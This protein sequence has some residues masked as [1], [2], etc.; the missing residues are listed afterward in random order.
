MMPSPWPAAACNG[1][2]CVGSSLLTLSPSHF[3]RFWRRRQPFGCEPTPT[4][5]VPSSW[6]S[7]GPPQANRKGDHCASGPGST[8]LGGPPN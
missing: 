6:A 1:W 8:E 4:A 7:S 5:I 3:L 2:T